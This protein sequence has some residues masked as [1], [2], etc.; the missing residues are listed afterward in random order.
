MVTGGESER[1]KIIQ[2]YHDVPAYGHPGIN[3]TKE[4]V[5][6]YYWWPQLAQDAQEYVKGCANC[7]WNKVNTHPQKAT[8]S[9]ITPSTQA[10][11]F[12]TIAM[13]F[14]VKLPESAGFDSILTITDHDCTKMLIMVPCR[15]T[16]T[17][18]GVAELVLRQVFPRFGLPSKIISDRDPR[19]ISNFMKEL[20]R[21]MGITQ[22]VS[23]AYHPR[24]DGQSERSNQWLEQYLR[25]WVDH[26]Q[27]N[28]HHYLPL[29]EFAHNSWK[30]ETTGQSPF[31]ILMG[32]SPRAEIF[33]VVRLGRAAA[34]KSSNSPVSAN[35]GSFRSHH[36]NP[37]SR[38][39]PRPFN[40]HAAVHPLLCGPSFPLQSA[41]FLTPTPV[42]RHSKLFPSNLQ[43]LQSFQ[44]SHRPK[45]L[46]SFQSNFT[47]FHPSSNQPLGPDATQESP[48]S[49]A[50]IAALIVGS[51]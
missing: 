6:K 16:M 48:L 7:Q 46:S 33:D 25:F 42:L 39:S 34:P 36:S 12:Q 31:E 5:A 26:Q 13:N 51:G 3:R 43:S 8:L 10:L 30:N 40:S 45:P 24:T 2:A 19:F 18:E 9:P 21:L 32:N 38:L 15:E 17:A 29:A 50:L 22:N 41:H 4:L 23:T 44:P 37:V 28:W 27:T 47:L 11:P 20:C 49:P 1:R 35:L 14:I